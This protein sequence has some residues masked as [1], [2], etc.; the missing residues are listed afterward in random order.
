MELF[1]SPHAQKPFSE[2]VSVGHV[3]ETASTSWPS[4]APRAHFLCL[5]QNPV[6]PQCRLICFF[7]VA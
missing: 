3:V 7:R 6:P 2:Y 5:M 4:K 1:R